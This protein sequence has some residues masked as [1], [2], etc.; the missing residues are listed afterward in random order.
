MLGDLLIEASAPPAISLFPAGFM[1]PSH[2]LLLQAPSIERGF[3]RRI[4]RDRRLY[5]G[6]RGIEFCRP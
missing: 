5:Y 4:D 2:F 6:E 3:N 1:R